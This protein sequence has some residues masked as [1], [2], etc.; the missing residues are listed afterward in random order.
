MEYAK[1][2]KKQNMFKS[3]EINQDNFW[4]L[5]QDEDTQVLDIGFRFNIDFEEKKDLIQALRNRKS[6]NELRGSIEK[7]T[8]IEYVYFLFNKVSIK[9]NKFGV[10]SIGTNVEN[11]TDFIIIPP[12]LKSLGITV[13][14]KVS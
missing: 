2:I 14:G 4:D 9:L 3:Y 11:I 6:I 13:R 7:E 12:L 10:L 8:E 1:I 5:L